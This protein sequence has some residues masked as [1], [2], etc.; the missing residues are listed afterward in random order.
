MFGYFILSIL[1]V[2]TAT[3]RIPNLVGINP[4]TPNGRIVGGDSVSIQ[5]YPHQVSLQ[6]YGFGFCGGSIISADWVLTAGHC[7][8]YPSAWITVRAGT[9]QFNSGGSIHEVEEVVRHEN[10]RT[11]LHGIPENDVALLKLKT[12]LE[13]DATRKP[14]SLFDQDEEA[15][16]GSLSTITGWGALKEGG[17]TS[18]VLQ[19]VNVPIVSKE[20]CSKAYSSYGGLP[21]GQI[22]AAHPKG[23]KDACQGDSGG[24]LTIYGRLAGIVSWGNG[25]ARKGFPGVYTE[26]ASFRDWIVRHAGL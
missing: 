1:S 8:S 22:C 7:T 20:L 25:C 9:S 3:D 18:R 12:P 15:V 21:D 4:F 5:E 11:N 13:L 14:V 17:S 2:V 16:E 10:Y 24:P 19:T 23:G 6:A 26:V